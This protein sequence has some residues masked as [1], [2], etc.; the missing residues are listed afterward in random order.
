MKKV[1]TAVVGAAGLLYGLIAVLLVYR[2]A[3]IGLQTFIV[4][5]VAATGASVGWLVG[6]AA[7]L[8]RQKCRTEG[9]HTS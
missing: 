3:P 5:S 2:D 4:A 7:S 9:S 1:S 6:V 8:V